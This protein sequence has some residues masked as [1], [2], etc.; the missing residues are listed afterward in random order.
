MNKLVVTSRVGWGVD[1]YGFYWYNTEYNNI[2]NNYKWDITFQN[3]E[4]LCCIHVAYNTTLAISQ[5]KKQVPSLKGTFTD[6]EPRKLC[7]HGA[8]FLGKKC[9]VWQL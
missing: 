7:L 6:V 8:S 3:C 5:N 4:S 2:Y 9:R 1:R